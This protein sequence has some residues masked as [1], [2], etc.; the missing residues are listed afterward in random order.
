MVNTTKLAI[1]GMLLASTMGAAADVNVNDILLRKKGNDINVRVI[2][3]NPATKEQKGPVVVTLF[4]R[5]NSAAKWEKIKTW[6]DIA[7]IKAGDK[8]SRDIF[9]E[10]SAPLCN[11]ASSVEWQAKATV[12]APGAKSKEKT[13]TNTG[14]VK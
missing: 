6:N 12:T 8:V 7:K 3:G 2:V 13:V 1:A 14:D 11:V 5:P 9:S 10:N 4:V